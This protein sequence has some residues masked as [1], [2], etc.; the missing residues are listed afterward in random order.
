[1]VFLMMMKVYCDWRCSPCW[2]AQSL[3]RKRWNSWRWI[4]ESR[5]NGNGNG[6]EIGE[7]RF[8]GERRKRKTK[9]KGVTAKVDEV[10]VLSVQAMMR[11]FGCFVSSPCGENFF[12]VLNLFILSSLLFLKKKKKSFLI[13]FMLLIFFFRGISNDTYFHLACS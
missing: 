3:E 10:W 1:M 6:E 7:W 12:V 11:F 8:G 2:V 13:N 4:S 9:T 5:W